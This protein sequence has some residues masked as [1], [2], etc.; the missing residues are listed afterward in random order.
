[1]NA[2]DDLIS[3]E[4][5]SEMLKG[6]GLR[7][8]VARVNLLQCLAAQTAPRTQ[9]EIGEELAVH[10]FD[11]STI[12]R[13]L[14]DL[15]ESGLVV[16]IDAGDRVW[17]FELHD[18]NA[19]GSLAPHHHSHITC[20]QCGKLTCLNLSTTDQF[21]N[22]VDDWTIEDL[23]LRGTC[24]ECRRPNQETPSTHRGE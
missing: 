24:A 15:T 23:I 1:M 22:A 3:L 4:L 20:Q 19:D 16:R 18:R 5:A 12:F 8:T 10:G 17:R 7:R 14:T 6:V 2:D 13:G 21:C 9:S 11:D